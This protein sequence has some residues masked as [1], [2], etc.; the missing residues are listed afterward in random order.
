MDQKAGGY[1]G[2][3]TVCVTVCVCVRCLR[4]FVLMVT[5]THPCQNATLPV[6]ER[7]MVLGPTGGEVYIVLVVAALQRVERPVDLAGK[8]L[9]AVHA[10]PLEVVT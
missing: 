8:F 2:V 3:K 4:A 5:T 7:W 10:F 9:P 1:V 6:T